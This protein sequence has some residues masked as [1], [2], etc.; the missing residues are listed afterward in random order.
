MVLITKVLNCEY[1]TISGV[2]C[3]G[4]FLGFHIECKDVI[5]DVCRATPPKGAYGRFLARP[6]SC[7]SEYS[8]ASMENCL[9]LWVD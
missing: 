6:G 8:M 7:A 9:K 2:A 5:V 4:C 3:A 1:A